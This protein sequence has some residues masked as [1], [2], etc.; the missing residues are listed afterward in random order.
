MVFS[1][2]RLHFFLNLFF[3]NFLQ[4]RKQTAIFVTIL[5]FHTYSGFNYQ[6]WHGKLYIKEFSILEVVQM[7]NFQPK[8]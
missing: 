4:N 5:K 8:R 7:E 1:I 6:Y 3:Y 2:Y